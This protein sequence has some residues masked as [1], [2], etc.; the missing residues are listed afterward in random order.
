MMTFLQDSNGETIGGS[1]VG[2]HTRCKNDQLRNDLSTLPLSMHETVNNVLF[3]PE[4][5]GATHCY[6]RDD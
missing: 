4:V 2:K 3:T 6:R 5:L 1:H